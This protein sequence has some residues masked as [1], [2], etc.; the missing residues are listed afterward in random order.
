[1]VMA[2]LCMF[3]VVFLIIGAAILFGLAIKCLADDEGNNGGLCILFS[4]ILTWIIVCM[5][6]LM[7]YLPVGTLSPAALR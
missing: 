4:V 2:K 5:T 1:M 7:T 3:T 6:W